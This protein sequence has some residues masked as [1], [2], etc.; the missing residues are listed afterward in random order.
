MSA[1]SAARMDSIM[2]DAY[3]DAEIKGLSVA[4]IGET[5]ADARAAFI[6]F[7][8]DAGAMSATFYSASGREE[9]R[10]PNGGRVLL[11][12]LRDSLRGTTVDHIYIPINRL[13]PDMVE[14]IAPA[15]VTS[16]HAAIT[17]YFL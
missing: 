17:G 9:L 13:T 6:R 1:H 15:V 7:K 4:I 5:R 8:D 3:I 2:A 11:C 14:Q 16:E 10:T 12:A